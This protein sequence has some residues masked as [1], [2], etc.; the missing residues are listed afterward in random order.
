MIGIL[1]YGF[2]GKAV[3]QLGASDSVEIYDKYIHE[4]SDNWLKTVNQ[5]FVF[6]CVPTNL[7]EGKLDTSIVVEVA[8]LW[9]K[10]TNMDSVLIVKSTVPVGTIDYLQELL[11]TNRIVFNPEFLTERT[12]NVDF[13]TADE[14]IVG[15]TDL[16]I[17]RRVISLYTGRVKPFASK[18]TTPKI[19]ELI[20]LARN[21]LYAVKIEFMNEIHD[22]CLSLGIDYDDF[23]GNFVWEGNNAWV[24]D[25]HTYVPGPDG[26]KGFG[27]K[28]LPKD[29]V[30]LKAVF[31]QA[32]CDAPVLD[33]TI[34]ANPPRRK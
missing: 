7:K 33:S 13:L 14:V 6:V 22:L 12:A 10:R 28:C 32:G 18:F 19:A 3:A 27:G 24:C 8:T 15:A 17:A 34:V 2:V 31:E 9:G 29:I 20:K 26:K 21:S 1:G 30:G 5:D 4:Y 16:D 23:R 25:Q 11:D